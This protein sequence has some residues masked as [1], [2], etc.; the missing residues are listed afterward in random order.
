MVVAAAATAKP[1][2]GA[3]SAGSTVVVHMAIMVGETVHLAAAM[4]KV[5]TAAAA[6]RSAAVVTSATA[7]SNA[8]H[9]QK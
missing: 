9:P 1:K 6:A 7:V 8:N 4:V 5:V 2:V 3:C